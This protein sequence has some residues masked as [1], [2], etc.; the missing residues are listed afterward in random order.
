[1]T[2]PWSAFHDYVLPDLP[3]APAAA[4]D[5]ALRQA[6]I[7]FCEKSLA[8]R[9]AH[10]K[11]AVTSG[12]ASYAFVPLSG[13]AV[14]AITYAEFDGDEI[15]CNAGELNIASA[16]DD[17]RN[18]TG[19]PEYIVG[20]TTSLQ[21]VPAPDAGGTLTLKVALKPSPSATGIDDDIFN[22]YREAIVHG[23]LARM[24]LS[25]KKPYSSP[26]LAQYHAQ[27]FEIKTGQAGMRQARNYSRAPLQTGI[28]RR[29]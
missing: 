4:V 3:G 10:P 16:V 13:A 14:H 29:G 20:G 17:W 15:E 12:T 23:A 8:W 1:M 26:Q 28:L 25:P 24:M 6:A 21:L 7:S 9:Y 5:I 27:Q 22:E 2:T 18:A 11:I 19:T